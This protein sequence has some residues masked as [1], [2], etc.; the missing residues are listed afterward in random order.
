M[1]A[2]SGSLNRSTSSSTPQKCWPNNRTS[3]SSSTVEGR[4]EPTS[5]AGP[6]GRHNVR[7]VDVQ[8]K[9]RLPEVLAAATSIS[10]PFD[11]ASRGR[12]CR[13]RPTRS[14]PPD[15]RSSPASTPAR[16]W[17][18]WWSER[19]QAS[20]C[21]PMIP[22]PSRTRSRGS[23]WHPTRPPAWVSP[24]EPMSSDG[25][26]PPRSRPVRGAVRRPQSTREKRYRTSVASAAKP[27]FHVIFL[28]SSAPRPEYEIG[29]S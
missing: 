4:P 17:P 5:S 25:H 13:R 20:R 6:V 19:V 23:S 26:H 8:P 9:R 2:T 29:T 3:C 15:G 1:P 18:I 21:H 24:V 7:F 14:W 27:S 10:F 12:A 28:P 11:V 22:R 16:R